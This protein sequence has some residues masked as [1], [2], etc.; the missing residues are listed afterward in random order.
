M[1]GRERTGFPVLTVEKGVGGGG[2]G[3]VAYRGI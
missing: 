1:V 3:S 2:G